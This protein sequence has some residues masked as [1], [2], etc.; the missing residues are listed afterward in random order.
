MTALGYHVRLGKSMES[1]AP[2]A[3]SP[4][5]LSTIGQIG[6]MAIRIWKQAQ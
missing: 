6:I 2:S 4:F 5:G 3:A 1:A